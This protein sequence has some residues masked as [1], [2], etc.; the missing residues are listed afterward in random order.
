MHDGA[1][2]RDAV[3]EPIDV[4]LPDGARVRLR[5]IRPDDK[6]ALRAGFE[7]LSDDAR[8][9]RFLVAMSRL[10]DEQLAYLTEVDQHDHIAWVV[11]DPETM[12]EGIGVGRCVRLAGTDIA[13]VALAITDAWQGRGVGRALFDVLT[14]DARA[15]GFRALRA[16]TRPDNRAML[17]LLERRGAGPGR[18]VDG[19]VEVD[20]PL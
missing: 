1:G 13:E 3:D 12:T 15:N 10:T 7:G 16:V 17:H 9:R 20:L 2:G 5:R 19:L 4:T 18:F 8:T 6:A 11:G 14:R